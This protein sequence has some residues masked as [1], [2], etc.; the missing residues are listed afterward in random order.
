MNYS[1]IL[2]KDFPY[3]VESKGRNPIFD[4]QKPNDYHG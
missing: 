3:T 4:D 1:L 2:I